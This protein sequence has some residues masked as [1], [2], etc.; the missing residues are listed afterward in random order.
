MI[1]F[2]IRK[3]I[4]KKI[5]WMLIFQIFLIGIVFYKYNSY[6]FIF[7][8]VNIVVLLFQ[9][10]LLFFCQF[11]IGCKIDN[12][13]IYISYLIF[14]KIKEKKMDIN[15]ITFRITTNNTLRG[16]NL[17]YLRLFESNKSFFIIDESD[18]N[19]ED[20]DLVI[21]YFKNKFTEKE[22]K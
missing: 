21:Y 2:G 1:Y 13:V 6:P 20:M 15:K 19:E 10:I 12:N 18:L 8:N 14:F 7:I 4:Q 22:I 3:V 5:I 17:R 11:F 16:G 9:T